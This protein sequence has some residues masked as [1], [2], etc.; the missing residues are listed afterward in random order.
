MENFEQD[1]KDI[2]EGVVQVMAVAVSVFAHYA[3]KMNPEKR[4]DFAVRSIRIALTRKNEMGKNGTQND[5]ARLAFFM[6]SLKYAQ[7]IF[8]VARQIESS[9]ETEKSENIMMTLANNIVVCSD[10][11]QAV[12]ELAAKL[13]E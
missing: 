3:R 5:F 4:N 6:D 2:G 7:E 8:I 12:A 13:P 10:G 11:I 9:N 1:F